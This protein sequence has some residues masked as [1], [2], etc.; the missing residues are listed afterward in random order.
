MWNNYHAGAMASIEYQKCADFPSLYLPWEWLRAKCKNDSQVL[1]WPA[2]GISITTKK[3]FCIPPLLLVLFG[4]IHNSS[5]TNIFE[6]KSWRTSCIVLSI[7]KFIF[8]VSCFEIRIMFWT[9]F[10]TKNKLRQLVLSTSSFYC[11]EVA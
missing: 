10:A 1:V 6:E 3:F 2:L 11:D 4:G 7:L 5:W 9:R 8:Y